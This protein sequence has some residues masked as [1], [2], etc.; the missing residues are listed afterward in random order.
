MYKYG[1]AI[2]KWDMGEEEGWTISECNSLEEKR[3]DEKKLIQQL[4]AI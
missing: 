1:N 4:R 3:E 2:N